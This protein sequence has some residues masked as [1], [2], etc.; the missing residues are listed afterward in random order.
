M[1]SFAQRLKLVISFGLL[2]A[3]IGVTSGNQAKEQRN[4]NSKN[5]AP[6][7]AVENK[8]SQ[9]GAAKLVMTN[10]RSNTTGIALLSG[11]FTPST[12]S[13]IVKSFGP[14]AAPILRVIKTTGKLWVPAVGMMESFMNAPDINDPN[15]KPMKSSDLS[16]G[17][18]MA[19]I[20]LPDGSEVGQTAAYTDLKLLKN[21]E[22]IQEHNARQWLLESLN[23]PESEGAV[24]NP[25]TRFVNDAESPIYLTVN[26]FGVA[27]LVGFLETPD[28]Q[29]SLPYHELANQAF[30]AGEYYKVL[31]YWA[32]SY[33]AGTENDDWKKAEIAKLRSYYILNFP[34]SRQRALGELDW[35]VGTHP[36]PEISA[37]KTEW[38]GH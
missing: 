12:Q 22:M 34:G 20:T 32:R 29:Q 1:K 38:S 23:S 6:V 15:W 33:R 14:D 35:M 8:A 13:W 11:D 30:S 19:R 27:E 37:L 9:S 17:I 3:V 5:D 4:M 24:I 26:R 28:V 36:S 10:S 7:K 18:H 21:N 25:K 2:I 31:Y 16:Y